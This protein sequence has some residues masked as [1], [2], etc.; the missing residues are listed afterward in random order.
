MSNDIP[1]GILT[2]YD[3]KIHLPLEKA[4]S[5]GRGTTVSMCMYYVPA[6][7]H[8]KWAVYLTSF[9]LPNTDAPRSRPT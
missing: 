3:G 8:G 7:A 5:G 6:R 2:T 1:A 9:A 4:L